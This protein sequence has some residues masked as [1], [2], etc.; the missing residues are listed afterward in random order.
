MA[1][2][3]CMSFDGEYQKERPTFE[4]PEAAWEYSNDLGS[5]WYFYPFHFVTSDSY[6]TIVSAPDLMRSLEGKRVQTV[7][8]I[9]KKVSERKD[10]EGADVDRFAIAIYSLID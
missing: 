6:K 5:K 2:I 3:I 10:M 4:T 1:K 8:N 9:F 7:A